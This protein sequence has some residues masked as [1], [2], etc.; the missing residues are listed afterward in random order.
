MKP[1]IEDGNAGA[2]AGSQW[3]GLLAPRV[4]QEGFRQYLLDHVWKT[5][6]LVILGAQLSGLLAI[7][8]A[9]DLPVVTGG[10]FGARGGLGDVALARLPLLISP[11][12]T[13]AGLW[14]LEHK[15][16]AV[17]WLGLATNTAYSVVTDLGFYL[18]GYSGSSVQ[19]RKSVV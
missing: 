4:V 17:A 14:A 8:V 7:G 16:D 2:R 11:L 1:V 3:A 9:F 13:V 6:L 15:P 18:L 10:A 19:D 12:L 5:R